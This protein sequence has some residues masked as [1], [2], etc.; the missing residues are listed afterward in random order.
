MVLIKLLKM[1]FRS[2]IENFLSKGKCKIFFISAYESNGFTVIE[3][4]YKKTN[5]KSK[6][7]FKE[8]SWY[9]LP[10]ME[11]INY[12]G[13]LHEILND[14]KNKWSKGFYDIENPSNSLKYIN[15]D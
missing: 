12:R 13:E 8:F 7:L 10:Y 15:N 9:T 14:I 11:E 6:F 2:F 4:V 5:E 1:D 3:V